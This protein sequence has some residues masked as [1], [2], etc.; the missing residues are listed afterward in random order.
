[1]HT[2]PGDGGGDIEM[3]AAMRKNIRRMSVH[4]FLIYTPG[5]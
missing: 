4:K 2:D 5:P 3:E 1:M